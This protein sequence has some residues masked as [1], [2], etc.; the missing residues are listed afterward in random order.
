MYLSGDS[1]IL[2][3]DLGSILI[4][5][6]EGV[7]GWVNKEHVHFDRIA[8]ASTL[9]PK[10]SSSSISVI[11]HEDLPRTVV[12]SPSPPLRH[13][14]LP[15]V[16]EQEAGKK[17]SAEP[18]E[19]DRRASNPFELDSPL[20]TP[21]VESAEKKFEVPEEEVQRRESVMSVDS[22]NSSSFGGIAGFMMGSP[23]PPA[24]EHGGLNLGRESSPGVSEMNGEL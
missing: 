4:A 2:L 9:S 16:L 6:C 5:S 10:S 21:G 13:R 1:L 8:S 11:P 20:G 18:K 15:S 23:S 7:V 3:R 22:V 24:S 14:R 17:L 19:E 12:H